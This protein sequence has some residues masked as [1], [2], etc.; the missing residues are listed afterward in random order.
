MYH[1]IP[2]SQNQISQ[3]GTPNPRRAQRH[4]KTSPKHP[5][6]TPKAL[7][8]HS[9]GSREISETADADQRGSPRRPKELQGTPKAA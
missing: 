6:D 7:Q 3:G 8:K 4:F 1:T 5:D 2:A 9:K